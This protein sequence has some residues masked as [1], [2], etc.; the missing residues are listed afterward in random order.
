VGLGLG[1][2]LEVRVRVRSQALGLGLEL[3]LG[4]PELASSRLLHGR[5]QLQHVMDYPRVTVRVRV[6]TIKGIE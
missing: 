2:G 3:G 1:L 4:L 5:F 6:K